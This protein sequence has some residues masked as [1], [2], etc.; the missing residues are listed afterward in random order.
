MSKQ[1]EFFSQTHTHTLQRCLLLLIRLFQS[2]MTRWKWPCF[3]FLLADLFCSQIRVGM[4]QWNSMIFVKE[5]FTVF[6][7]TK[8][9]EKLMSRKLSFVSLSRKK[10]NT[11]NFY[12][13]LFVCFDYTR[14]RIQTNKNSH[15]ITLTIERYIYDITKN[16]FWNNVKTLSEY[17]IVQQLAVSRLRY[18]L[19]VWTRIVVVVRYYWKG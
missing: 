18:K 4:M 14:Q 8:R 15:S 7:P 10:K 12:F 2:E 13:L 9:K 11:T 5:I 16:K 6:E 3:L 1:L 17:T 19:S